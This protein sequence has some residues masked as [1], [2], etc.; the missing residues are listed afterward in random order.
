MKKSYF[1]LV[2]ILSFTLSSNAQ[3]IQNFDS[4]TTIPAGWGVIN[5][6]DTNTWNFGAPGDGLPAY[7]GNNVAKIIYNF[8]TAHNDYLVT[9][10][11]MV[12]AGVND[13]ITFR[14]KNRNINYIEHF[15]VKLSNTSPTSAANFTTT[16]LG[17]TAAPSTWT[18][19]TID[20]TPYIGQSIYIGFHATSLNMWEL[21]LDD[22][23]NDTTPVCNYN[24]PTISTVNL[25]SCSAAGSVTLN[26]LPSVGIWTLST[27]CYV[28]SVLN[29]IITTTTGT[30]TSTTVA[31]TNENSNTHTYYFRFI[32]EDG[33][34]SP[35]SNSV[36]VMM[37]YNYDE[38]FNGVY[39]DANND[40]IGNLGDQIHYTTT[41]AN[42][43]SCPMA[44]INLNAETYDHVVIFANQ[45]YTLQAQS[46]IN[47]NA[48]YN[49]TQQDISNGY[50]SAYQNNSFGS[51]RAITTAINTNG[52][53]M[54]AFV[55]L[56]YNNIK[57]TSEPLFP[58][59]DFQ[60]VKNNEAAVTINSSNGSYFIPEWYL[61]NS[62]NL[63]F[64][65]NS[66]FS[67]YITSS[68]T[69]YTGVT[70]NSGTGITDYYFPVYFTNSSGDLQVNI[71]PIG[72]TPRP[73]FEYKNRIIY[74]NSFNNPISGTLNFTK[75]NLVTI[76]SVSQIGTVNNTNGF[77]F[78]FNLQ[79]FEMKY[80]DVAMQVPS[81]LNMG[82]PLTN[83]ASITIPVDDIN[84]QNNTSS[85]TQVL[86]NSYDPNNKS[87]VHGGKILTTSFSAND[88]LTYTINFENVG[89]AD[90]INVEI[91][92]N[93]DYRLNPDSLI[94][95]S[96]SHD[97]ILEKTGSYL[98]WKF[99]SIHLPPLGKGYITFK[100]KPNFWNINT[101]TVIPNQAQIRFDFNSP[102][103]TNNYNTEFVSVLKNNNFDINEFQ[104]YPNPVKNNLTI[105][106]ASIIDEVEITSLLG[107]KMISKKV[108][109]LETEI[110]L[111][112][113]ANGVYFV[114]V[115]SN[116][117]EKTIKIVKE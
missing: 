16:L 39:V 92:D 51:N 67:N 98:S 75:D 91:M 107:Q 80:I 109:D 29:P 13:R 101:G 84:S 41:L 17:N 20:L 111:A 9:P 114:K 38:T 87:E 62:Y 35:I 110:S 90:A 105:S 65:V 18:K 28:S 45:S 66:A 106:N 50:V 8:T 32:D 73:G 72:S 3:F 103:T 63:S 21:Y 104:Y 58:F 15:D 81:T 1:I 88:Y 42:Y 36:Y 6:G 100:I 49:I 4:G 69:S 30:G 78:D 85:I 115:T 59:G 48:D 34:Q 116:G 108:N 94:E 43:G 22:I 86:I 33:C 26:G 5:G 47:L 25:P 11:I 27:I 2:F 93:L 74:F 53:R 95:I 44:P 99:N 70:S 54:N 102:I 117:Q 56:N 7:S 77:S 64:S 57:D 14:V 55:D 31:I 23:V 79:P 10:Q 24:A 97:Y 19:I 112:E 52:I 113:L 68:G 71:I 60:Y 96:S 89:N 46:T 12:V 82:S 76:N 61:G 37:K 83:S 40:G